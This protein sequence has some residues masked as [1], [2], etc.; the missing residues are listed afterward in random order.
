MNKII[1]CVVALCAFGVAENSHAGIIFS[2]DFES[3]PSSWVCTQGD[4]SKWSAGYSNCSSTA[5]FGAEWKMGAGRSS[6]NALYSWKKMGVPNGYRGEAQKWLTGSDV[7]QEIYHRWYMKVPGS[8]VYNKGID[9]GFKFWRYIT[10]ANGFSGPD[11]IYLN[12]RGTTFAGG[13]L[14]IY[15]SG[16][17]AYHDLTNVS[18]FNDNQWHCHEL[19]IKINSSGMS[20][21]IIQYWLDGT[22]KATYSNLRLDKSA[23]QG[24][25]HRIGVGMGNVSDNDW[26][27]AEW[28]AVGFDDVV[29][30][31]EYIGPDGVATSNPDMSA[32][33]RVRVVTP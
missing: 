13:K 7:K 12:V 20:D 32:P 25:I 33:T 6:I 17:S 16:S 11:E 18:D 30:A 27:Q 22:L 8:A 24:G 1:L 26:Y 14:T 21:G 10:R 29:V 3:Y 15:E 4:L 19:R 31:T 2:D 28:S 23:G 9:Q 5:G